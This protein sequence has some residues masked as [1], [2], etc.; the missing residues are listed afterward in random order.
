MDGR[1]LVPVVLCWLL[2]TSAVPVGVAAGGP[3]SG[4]AAA[5]ATSCALDSATVEDSTTD[6]D[7]TVGPTA[8]DDRSGVR[9]PTAVGE[10][11]AASG[12]SVL[13]GG[14]PDRPSGPSDLREP[15]AVRGPDGVA[16]PL[17]T[18][19]RDRQTSVTLSRD[20]NAPIDVTVRLNWTAG[21]RQIWYEY[22]IEPTEEFDRAELVF[23]RA[24]DWLAEFGNYTVAGLEAGDDP[25]EYWWRELTPGETARITGSVTLPD[26]SWYA[27]TEAWAMMPVPTVNVWWHRNDSYVKADATER[28]VNGDGHASDGLVLFGDYV[29]T[30]QTVAG[31]NLSVLMPATA[32]V[33]TDSTLDRMTTAAEL[34]DVGYR[35]P[36]TDLFL[37]QAPV[38]RGGLAYRGQQSFWVNTVTAF[39]RPSVVYHEYVHTRQQYDPTPR[40]SW[41]IEAQAEYYEHLLA[42]ERGDIDYG[43]FRSRLDT[44]GDAGEVLNDPESDGGA[45]YTKG[46]RILAALDV[47]IRRATDGQRTFEHVWARLNAR[48]QTGNGSVTYG[49]FET[50][51]ERVAGQSMDDWLDRY[52]GGDAAPPLPGA[53]SRYRLT[54]AP[55]DLDG[56]GVSI[57]RETNAG[58]SPLETDSDGDGLSDEREFAGPTDPASADTDGDGLSDGREVDGP[59]NPTKPDTD[60]DGL[61]DGEEIEQG[62]DPTV[63]DTDGD[64]LDDGREQRLGTDP[65]ATDSDDD[66]LADAEEIERGTNPAKA[67]TD[68]DGLSDGEE[69][70]RGTSPTSPDTDSDRAG[71]G[72]EIE[73]GTD[74]T[75]PDTDGDGLEDGEEFGMATDPTTADTDGDGLDDGEEVQRGTDPTDP[76]SPTQ[77]ATATPTATPTT[78]DGDGFTVPLAVLVVVATLLAVRRWRR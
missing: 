41:I 19:G 68:S 72:E 13:N 18:A 31:Q 30:S 38:R 75:D 29:R 34:I 5:D 73:A 63:T 10:P 50:I 58:T 71:D 62:A 77:T 1:R 24:G 69:I 42:L 36:S 56:D 22:V 28:V 46:A 9:E 48:A 74:P 51:V 35:D 12:A 4:G 20:A 43:E 25:D 45:G 59:T 66:G 16:V 54:D 23:L 57:T 37:P 55:I 11:P 6:A 17:G 3:A 52:V 49:Q 39:E 26:R 53:E 70:E 2:I 78:T 33:P 44:S 65:T 7:A 60:G 67:D 14:L 8:V 32:D 27:A 40:L 76:D 15:T 21:E 64:G 47:K 61:D